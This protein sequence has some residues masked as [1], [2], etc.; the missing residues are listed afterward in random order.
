[1]SEELVCKRPFRDIDLYDHKFLNVHQND[2][3]LFYFF[4]MILRDV[5]RHESLADTPK[6]QINYIQHQMMLKWNGCGLKF[7]TKYFIEKDSLA[8]LRNHM[9][10]MDKFSTAESITKN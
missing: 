8:A 7:Q 10:K 2:D 1:M 5:G 4:N 6:D 9:R 3:M